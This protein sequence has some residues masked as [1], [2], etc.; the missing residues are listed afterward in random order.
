M[1]FN[2]DDPDIQ[3][4]LCNDSIEKHYSL[5]C[6][7][8]TLVEPSTEKAVCCLFE[9]ITLSIYDND[10]RM[11]AFR[12][13]HSRIQPWIKTLNLYFYEF[14]GKQSDKVIT[15]VDNPLTISAS[16]P[17]KSITIDV[18]NN[19]NDRLY[20]LTFFIKSGFIQAQGKLL[21]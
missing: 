12:T 1:S 17:L 6:L 9:E 20:K 13:I 18:K 10:A 11:A 14:L 21:H 3:K 7:P 2:I 4:F 19:K 5:D 8:S 15:W 16:Q